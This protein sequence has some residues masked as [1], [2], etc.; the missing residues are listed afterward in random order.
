[1]TEIIVDGLLYYYDKE[2]TTF[3][4]ENFMIPD[5]PTLERVSN[6]YFSSIDTTGFSPD[7]FMDIIKQAK[8]SESYKATIKL[9]E[10]AFDSNVNEV[11]ILKIIVPIY[12]SACRKMGYVKEGLDTTLYYYRHYNIDSSVLFTTIGSSYCD[13]EN[14]DK[15][16]KFANKAY[17]IQGGG[18]GYNNELSLLYKRI[19]KLSPSHSVLEDQ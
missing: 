6:S 14:Y 5:P 2:R 18:V 1:M 7:Q 10:K 17:A 4:D 13:L 15:A 19:R 8:K 3:F 12:N 11:D 9:C 16:L